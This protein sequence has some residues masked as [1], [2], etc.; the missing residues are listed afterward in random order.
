MDRPNASL[1][2][3]VNLID[4]DLS[5]KSNTTKK[6]SRT[7]TTTVSD[8]KS[9]RDDTNNRAESVDVSKRLS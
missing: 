3:T 5:T 7:P 1:N 2:K 8:K 9:S 6:S 4:S